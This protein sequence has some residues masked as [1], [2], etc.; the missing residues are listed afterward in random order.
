M[1]CFW[2]PHFMVTQHSS[3]DG[4]A[5]RPAKQTYTNYQ[6]LNL[7]EEGHRAFVESRRSTLFS[8]QEIQ[9]YASQS[10]HCWTGNLRTVWDHKSGAILKHQVSTAQRS[11][12][13]RA[14]SGRA[15][16][17]SAAG[18]RRTLFHSRLSPPNNPMSFSPNPSPDTVPMPDFVLPSSSGRAAI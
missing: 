9:V 2:L 3:L 8:H 14:A 5:N 4:Q 11:A 18:C 1:T 7:R 17:L 10:Y 12:A 15:E 13:Q 16:A 6:A